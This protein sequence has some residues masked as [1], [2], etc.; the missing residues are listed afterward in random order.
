MFR[1]PVHG[2]IAEFSMY[3][4]NET[5][6]IILIYFVHK[7]HSVTLVRVMLFKGLEM[8]IFRRPSTS[9]CV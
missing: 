4:Y 7:I 1:V 6:D 8:D 3:S 5:C 9:F 2:W